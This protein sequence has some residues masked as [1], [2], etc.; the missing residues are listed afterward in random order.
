MSTA[1]C[2][3][4][5]RITVAHDAVVVDGH[6]R[7]Q[8][9]QAGPLPDVVQG[10]L[11]RL[12]ASAQRL[13]CTCSR[14]PIPSMSSTRWS[15]EPDTRR[16]KS[17]CWRSGTHSLLQPA[18]LGC[19][20]PRLPMSSGVVGVENCPPGPPHFLDPF[21]ETGP[22]TIGT[23]VAFALLV[24]FV[25]AGAAAGWVPVVPADVGSVMRDALLPKLERLS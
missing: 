8:F 14:T 20:R 10:G 12:V 24:D 13:P 2:R 6:L 3:R 19:Q 11:S 5:G 23:V 16:R 15:A 17:R 7:R 25:E 1:P 21:V 9:L 22:I 4:T 18:F